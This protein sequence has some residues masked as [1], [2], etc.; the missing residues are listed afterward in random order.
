MQKVAHEAYKTEEVDKADDGSFKPF[1]PST[2]RFLLETV[3]LTKEHQ[4]KV[5]SLLFGKKYMF[6]R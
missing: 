6:S 5:A 1:S 2:L 3:P 4:E